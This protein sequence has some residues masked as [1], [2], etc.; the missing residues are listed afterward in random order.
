MNVHIVSLDLVFKDA[1]VVIP[2]SSQL[3]FI[4]GQVGTGK[5]SIARLVDWCLGDD[6]EFTPA[7]E[8]E[9]VSAGLHLDI[10]GCPTLVTRDREDKSHV[11]LSWAHEGE[12]PHNEIVPLKAAAGEWDAAKPQTLGD[13]LF[14]LAG[15]T[16]LRVPKSRKGD[17][18]TLQRLSFRD[19]LAFCYLPQEKLNVSLLRFGEAFTGRKS[20]DVMR[21]ILGLFSERQQ[22]LEARS[23]ALLRSGNQLRTQAE[24]VT[25]FLDRLEIDSLADIETQLAKARAELAEAEA[26]RVAA[27]RDELPAAHPSDALRRG[28]RIAEQEI[29]QRRQALVDIDERLAIDARLRAELINA[30]LKLDRSGAAVE[31]LSGV[32]YG[33][34][35]QCGRPVVPVA[36]ADT[37][38]LCHQA[39]IAATSPLPAAASQAD[40]QSRIDELAESLERH[41]A[42]RA[43]ESR[44]LREQ[45]VRKAEQ[46][47]VLVEMLRDYES[48]R[49]ANARQVERRYALARRDVERYTTAD[50]LRSEVKRLREESA[51]K[52]AARAPI[53]EDLKAENAKLADHERYR[54]VIAT[55]FH[56]ALLAVGMPDVTPQDTVKITDKLQ[57]LIEPASGR[58][59]YGFTNLGS[60]GMKT[61]FQCC[62][63]LALHRVA[64]EHDL[65]LPRFLIIDTPTQHVDERIDSEIFHGFFRYL[66]ELLQGPMASVQVVLIDSE[67]E[68]PPA[69][70]EMVHRLMMRDDPQHPR[71]VPYYLPIED[72][73]DKDGPVV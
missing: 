11:R 13:H 22:E 66:Y 5:S 6:M 32:Q 57:P 62:Y 15:V 70:I 25:A 21:A 48:K 61:L 20:E 24:E 18:T 51:K 46:D 64:A 52:L 16:P 2:F 49:L 55:A 45:E 31:V 41:R 47:A 29:D 54:G 30:Q 38:H 56:E 12:E 63:A 26:A 17:D 50:R 39:G 37:C 72:S 73:G 67:L 58:S 69:G 19:F 8:D 10:G 65:L 68:Q 59:S 60:S 14:V 44:Q 23:D 1:H 7:L 34:C 27:R 36:D 35:P 53:L 9:L 43:R 42:A 40:L 33:H 4:H 3:T 71:L 28:L